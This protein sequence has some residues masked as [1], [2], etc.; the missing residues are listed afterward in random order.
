MGAFYSRIFGV[1]RGR[2]AVGDSDNRSIAINGAAVEHRT[3]GACVSDDKRH[4]FS[5]NCLIIKLSEDLILR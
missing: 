4:C 5:Q 1:R 2:N 3:N